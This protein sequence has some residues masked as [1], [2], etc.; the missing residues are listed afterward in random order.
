MPYAAFNSLG[1]L[2]SRVGMHEQSDDYRRNDWLQEHLGSHY[3]LCGKLLCSM[4]P[5]QTQRTALHRASVSHRQLHSELQHCFC[6]KFCNGDT[7]PSANSEN[8]DRAVIQNSQ[9]TGGDYT[10]RLTFYIKAIIA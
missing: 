6:T 9:K 5:A 10:S 3:R 8:K 2:E 4:V 7:A 1:S